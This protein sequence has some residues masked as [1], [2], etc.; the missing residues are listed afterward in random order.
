MFERAKIYSKMRT[1]LFL[2]L[3]FGQ[4]LVG[5]VSWAKFCV[6]EDA[7]GVIGSQDLPTTDDDKTLAANEL[8][9]N[10]KKVC[11]SDTNSVFNPE[12][13]T[14]CLV[15]DILPTQLEN[16]LALGTDNTV[17]DIP[18]ILG[19]IIQKALSVVGALTLLVFVYGGFIWLTSAGKEDK[20]KHGSEAML[21]AV[22]GL[23]IV[24]G[25]YAMLSLILGKLT[26]TG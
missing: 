10:C 5:G 8:D 23:S 14:N 6:F 26:G 9:T 18:T 25:A 15:A 7:K 20:V 16:P 3:I 17:R 11:N 19:G 13:K 1:T 21:Y 4:F 2:F 22:I 12:Y 24:F